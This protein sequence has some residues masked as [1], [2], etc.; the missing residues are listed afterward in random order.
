VK[1]GDLDLDGLCS[2]LQKKAKCS[3]TGPIVQDTDFKD[4]LKKYLGDDLSKVCAES[5]KKTM[6][7]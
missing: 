5:K 7:P 3:G 6:I 2:E 4:I 1:S